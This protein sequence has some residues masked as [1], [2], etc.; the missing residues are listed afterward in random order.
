[1]KAYGGKCMKASRQFSKLVPLAVAFSLSSA[2]CGDGTS[3]TTPAVSLV[4]IPS[5]ATFTVLPPR[6]PPGSPTPS[7]CP[8]LSTSWTLSVSSTRSGDLESA[9]I[10]VR[11]T[12]SGA[13]IANESLD[14]AQLAAQGGT[15]VEAG[16]P[17]VVP[18]F[19]LKEIPADFSARSLLLRVE[20]TL[21]SGSQ[22]ATAS[23]EASLISPQ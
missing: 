12:T 11:D 4:V 16:T 8:T 14:Q 22:Q 17:L 13:V 18:Q 6:V 3:G 19:V 15:H 5:P 7:C 10:T 21:R 20:V 9:T 23:V 1:M 2:G